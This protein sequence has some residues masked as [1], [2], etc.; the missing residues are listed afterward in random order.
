M[1]PKG[2]DHLWVGVPPSDKGHF[3]YQGARAVYA[4]MENAPTSFIDVRDIAAV[5]AG[6]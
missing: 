3:S 5:A 2:A 1:R 4:S 6:R